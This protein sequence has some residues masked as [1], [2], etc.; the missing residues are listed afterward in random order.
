MTTGYDAPH[1]ELDENRGWSATKILLALVVVAMVAMWFWIY[2]FASRDNIDRLESREFAE[3]AEAICAP[4]QAEIDALPTGRD[5]ETPEERS[6]QVEQ[7]TRLTETMVA[8]LRAA[9]EV[10]LASAEDRALVEAWLTDWDFYIEDRWSHVDRLDRATVDTPDEDFRFT[11]R[12]RAG[13]GLYT[14]RMEGFANVNDM[15]SCHV[16]GDI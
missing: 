3:A 13:G 7:A 12:E 10:H 15:A 14:T 1:D 9:A 6:D 8:S 2:L 11:L 4:V 16:P 5:A